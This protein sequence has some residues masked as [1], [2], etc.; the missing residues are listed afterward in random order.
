MKQSR[1][2]HCHNSPLTVRVAKNRHYT[3]LALRGGFER[4]GLLAGVTPVRL[5]EEGLIQSDPASQK[6][7]RTHEI[8][9]VYL[10]ARDVFLLPSS[11]STNDTRG[12]I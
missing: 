11:S 5:V 10:R 9:G 6:G 4:N 2:R 7:A 8:N 3:H 1:N 12:F